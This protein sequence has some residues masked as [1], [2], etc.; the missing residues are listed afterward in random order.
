MSTM[1]KNQWTVDAI[2]ERL[3]MYKKLAQEYDRFVNW[4]ER[5]TFEIPFIQKQLETL[6]PTSE[7]SLEILEA[8]CGTGMHA[9]ALAKLG[10]QVSGADLIPEMITIA[11]ANAEAAG[12]KVKFITAG[13][14]KLSQDFGRAQFDGLLCLGNSL[15]HVLT[16]TDL[17]A[18][19]Q[20]FAACLKPGG[21]LLVQNRNFD[22]VMKNKNRWME[23]QTFSDN[24]NEW[25]FH[26]F[27]DFEDNDLIRF[28]IL[29]LKRKKGS[30]WQV[31]LTHTFLMPNLEEDLTRL[32]LIAGFESVTTFGSMDAKAFDPETSPNLILVA[33][34]KN[35]ILPV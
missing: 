35:Q 16:K 7:T 3:K 31:E 25:L 18:T 23:P 30:D 26:R 9:I 14:G 10:Y 11:R 21:L 29:T 20:D 32:M 1:P 33:T 28:N 15:P 4:Q 6:P 17:E 22:S 34:K 13:F 8:A 27:Y 12:Q 19:I 24:E 5:L 2:E